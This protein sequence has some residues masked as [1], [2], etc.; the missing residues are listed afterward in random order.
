MLAALNAV[1][2]IFCGQQDVL[3]MNHFLTKV[4]NVSRSAKLTSPPFKLLVL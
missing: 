2:F 4:L 1:W 3:D